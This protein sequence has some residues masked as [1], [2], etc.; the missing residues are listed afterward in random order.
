MSQ[1]AT[2]IWLKWALF[3]NSMRKSKAVIN[4]LA[5]ALTLLAAL[6]LS[7]LIAFGLGVAAYALTAPGS[8][9]DTRAL[10]AAHRGGG[11]GV[12]SVEFIFFSIFSLFY[13][14]WATLPLSIGGGRQFDPGNL[15]LYPISLRKLFA[16]DFLSEVATLQSL[17]AI[18]A[19]LAIGIGVGV[20]TGKMA[21][22]VLLALAA[23]AF[24]VALSKWVSTSIGSLI[25]RKRTRGETLLALIGAIAGLGGALFGQLAPIVFRHA[26][27][28]AAL[29]WTPPGAVAFALTRGL[30]PGH[31]PEYVLVLSLLVAYTSVL[32]I[33]TYWLTRRA[34]L[35]GGSAKQK[36]ERVVVAE[37]PYTGWNFPFISPELSAI[38]EKELRYS[39]RNA[40]LRMMTLMPLI[41]IVIRFINR[42]RFAAPGDSATGFSADFFDYGAGLMAT[43][44][45]LYVFLILAGLFCNQFA[46]DQAGMRTLIL[47]P[48]DRKKVL[49]GKNISLSLLAFAF[50]SGL[51]VVNEIVFQDLSAGAVLFAALSFVAFASLISL[52]GNWFSIHFPKRMKF[53]KR[54]N[55]SGVVG[56][57]LIPLIVLLALV[58]LAATAAGYVAQSVLVEYVTL[59]VLA[60]LSLGFYLL[61]LPSQGEAVQKRELAIHEAVNDPGND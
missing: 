2:L 51:L 45:I 39:T 6:A 58:P 20:G 54:L 35:G 46:F 36:P 50:C 18:P 44:G 34:T 26:D 23:S 43:T 16:L 17:F 8:G 30:R 55:V 56:L 4:R 61:L 22:A 42:R 49:L 33:V 24:G 29:R 25:R 28:I 9:I 14:L 59:A 10:T 32:V 21:A 31:M 5:S 47:S 15:L 13:L 37:K 27:S 19:V 12:P 3:R 40:Q 48:V 7:L 57:L 53:G 41:L 1:L 11:G 52:I 38:I 60:G